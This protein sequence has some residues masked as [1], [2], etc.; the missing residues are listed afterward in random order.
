MTCINMSCGQTFLSPRALQ[1]MNR[2]VYY[3]IYYPGYYEEEIETVNMLKEIYNTKN[4]VLII[5]GTGT[6]GLE[7]GFRSLF[8]PEEKVLV[9]N[10]G[11]FGEVGKCL[12]EIIGVVPIDFKVS[13]GEEVNLKAVREVLEKTPNIIGLFVVHDE[14][15]TGAIQPVKELGEIASEF[16]L[17]YTVDAISSIGGVELNIDKCGIDL[18]FG[19]AQKCINGPQ[20]LVTVSV[21]PKAWNKIKKRKSL[22]TSLCLDLEVWKRY[23]YIKVKK[24][25]EWWQKGGEEPKFISKAPHEVSPPAT[26]VLG[27]KG[28]LEDIFEEGLENV[29]K[30]H[31]IAGKA[32]RQAIDALGLE[33]V[34]KNKKIVSNMVT[35][36]RLPNGIHERDFREVM[37]KKYSI[38]IGNGE[39]G[40]DNVRI[41]TM[42][43]A[44]SYKYVLPTIFAIG[45]TLEHFGVSVDKREALKAASEVFESHNIL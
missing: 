16:D 25:Y 43:I 9:I 27:L 38:A 32:V 10:T 28:A 30:R 5:T 24:S 13:Y 31:R 22:N 37:L 8:E 34:T 2:Q 14:T 44:A 11:I 4:D 6:Y 36:V 39:I 42:G 40:Q 19:N 17:L 41:G 15:T 35:A 3:P 18:C 12:L 20:G 7:A 45:N 21:S 33:R 23:Q 1:N 26:L 29:F